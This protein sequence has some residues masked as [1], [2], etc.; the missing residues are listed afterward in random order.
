[1]TNLASSILTHPS[2]ENIRIAGV[3]ATKAIQAANA[4]EDSTEM[5]QMRGTHE[6]DLDA[7]QQDTKTAC[8]RVKSVALFNMGV[9]ATVSS[10]APQTA[11]SP[12][13]A[14]YLLTAIDPLGRADE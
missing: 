9:I 10:I 5:A 3:W 1:M 8:E 7:L 2:T 14:S 4:A 13:T 11:G 12:S 6:D